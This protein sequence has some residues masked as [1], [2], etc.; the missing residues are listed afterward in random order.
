MEQMR[1]YLKNNDFFP[2]LVIF[3]VLSSKI[4]EFSIQFSKIYKP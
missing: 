3:V 1:F 2:Y 4:F